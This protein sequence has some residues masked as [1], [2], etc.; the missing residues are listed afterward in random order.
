[1][2][3]IS[4]LAAQSA[5][6]SGPSNMQ[7]VAGAQK[8]AATAKV[9]ATTKTDKVELN[10]KMAGLGQQGQ[11]GQKSTPFPLFSPEIESGIGRIQNLISSGRQT[12]GSMLASQK[13]SG[14]SK[15]QLAQSKEAQAQADAKA[16]ARKEQEFAQKSITSPANASLSAVVQNLN[17]EQMRR[18]TPTQQ[19][20]QAV[21][22]LL[23]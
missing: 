13:P 11:Q 14:A 17:N 3:I 8:Q 20:S 5:L 19:Q 2:P 23:V 12:P 4:S 1:M 7:N 6:G 10:T 16:M 9:Q 18:G 22:Q 21:S 15:G